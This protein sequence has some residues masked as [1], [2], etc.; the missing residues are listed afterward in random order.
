MTM[1]IHPFVTHLQP[2]EAYTLIEFLD[3][4]RDAL[5]QTYGDEINTMLQQASTSQIAVVT[6]NNE[7]AF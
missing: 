7:E 6:V 5:M 1:R 3:Q 2:G 4:I